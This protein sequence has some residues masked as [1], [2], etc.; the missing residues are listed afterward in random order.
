M[1]GLRSKPFQQILP[2]R[3]QYI[4]NPMYLIQLV[5]SRKQRLFGD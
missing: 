5:F 3:T 2:R 1:R 4:I